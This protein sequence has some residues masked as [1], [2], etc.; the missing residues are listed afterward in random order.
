[1][2]LYLASASGEGQED[3]LFHGQKVLLPVA[4]KRK[5]W[6]DENKALKFSVI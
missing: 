1:M 2:E 5:W 4:Q 6:G 3:N